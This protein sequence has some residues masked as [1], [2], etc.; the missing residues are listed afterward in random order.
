MTGL[1]DE[2]EEESES[3]LSLSLLST[4]LAFLEPFLAASAWAATFFFSASF[5]ALFFESSRLCFLDGGSD[6]LALAT[7]FL[8]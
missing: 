6:E 8:D 3:L 4:F 1:A 7:C 5:L 2:S